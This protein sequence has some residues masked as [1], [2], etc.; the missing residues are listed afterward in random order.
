ML[1]I[2]EPGRLGTAFLLFG[3]LSRLTGRRLFC[4]NYYV[5][6]NGTAFQPGTIYLARELA[7]MTT[8]A[9][10]CAALRARNP[11]L[12]GMFPNAGVLPEPP[13]GRSRVQR[14]LE[15]PLRGAFGERV[16]RWGRRVA[17]SRLRA[18]Y[19]ALGQDVPPDVA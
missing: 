10:T 2:T 11:W 17:S 15:R 18:H 12:A 1:L 6:E 8:L 7:Q 5:S 9:G 19:R 3:P 4:P 14:L 16:E 13:R